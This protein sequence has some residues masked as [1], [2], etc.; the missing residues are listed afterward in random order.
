[1]RS[2]VQP[3]NQHSFGVYKLACAFESDGEPSH[4]KR[5]P[6]ILRKKCF[7]EFLRMTAISA[8]VSAFRSTGVDAAARNGI[9]LPHCLTGI[10]PKQEAPYGI[11]GGNRRGNFRD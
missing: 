5:Y 1:M 6:E 2:G 9:R 8:P 10:Y 11:S 4:S 7:E 3:P